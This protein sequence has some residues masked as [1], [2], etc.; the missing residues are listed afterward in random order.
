[1][2]QLAKQ[3]CS[4]CSADSTPLSPSELT[5]VLKELPGWVKTNGDAP[6]LQRGYRFT[7]FTDALD[8]ANAIGELAE[9]FDHHPTLTIEWGMVTVQ[10]WTHKIDNIHHTDAVL[11][12]KCDVIYDNS[13]GQADQ[14]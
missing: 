5:E 4:A 11:A 1:M 8:F 14:D 7:N 10:W 12:A 3:T 2:T 9:E 6:K 13:K